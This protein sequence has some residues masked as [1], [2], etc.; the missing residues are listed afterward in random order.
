MSCRQHARNCRLQGSQGQGPRVSVAAAVLSGVST[1][2]SESTRIST[3]RPPLDPE[4]L[5]SRHPCRGRLAAPSKLDKVASRGIF[6]GCHSASE[7]RQPA[8]RV[9]RVRATWELDAFGLL[10][11]GNPSTR[12]PGARFVVG[13]CHHRPESV[14]WIDRGADTARSQDSGR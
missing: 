14:D 2:R 4:Q 6:I 12:P 9:F 13:G 5:E 10:G 1:T 3:R 11:Q 7:I 8:T